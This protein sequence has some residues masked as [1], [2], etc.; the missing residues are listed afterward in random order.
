M[1]WRPA[2]QLNSVI[3]EGFQ[4]KAHTVDLPNGYQ[5]AAFLVVPKTVEL[6]VENALKLGKFIAGLEEH[7]LIEG[8]ED[9]P[10]EIVYNNRWYSQR[11]QNASIP[12]EAKSIE[13]EW[14][15]VRDFICAS[16]AHKVEFCD[17]TKI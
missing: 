2:L 15:R 11:I 17:S 8:I 14:A 9:N 12:A 10:K 5:Y 6:L 16:I 3:I 7:P 1:V 4:E 13:L